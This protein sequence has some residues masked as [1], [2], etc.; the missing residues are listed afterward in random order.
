MAFEGHLICH[1]RR[2][3]FDIEAP[4]FAGAA[5]SSFQRDVSND[6]LHRASEPG[7]VAD[8]GLAA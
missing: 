5:C 7:R 1:P 4:L 8:L 2:E 6:A 3:R